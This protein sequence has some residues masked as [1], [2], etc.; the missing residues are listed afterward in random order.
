[1]TPT[2]QPKNLNRQM[3]LSSLEHFWLRL[4]FLVQDA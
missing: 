3:P 1:M 2:P 4:P